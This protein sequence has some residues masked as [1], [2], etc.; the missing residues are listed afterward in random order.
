MAEPSNIIVE[1][2]IVGV[3][4]FKKEISGSVKEAE[5]I[6]ATLKDVSDNGSKAINT[7]TSSGK[8]LKTQMRESTAT[9][10][11]LYL[12]I[13]KLKDSGDKG[14]AALKD[15][16]ARA[17]KLSMEA[18]QLRDAMSDA[19][20]VI[21]GAGSDTRGLDR[22]LRTLTLFGGAAQIAEGASAA[23]G[24]ENENL[25]KTLVRLNA[26]MAITNGLQQIQD[27]LLKEDSVAKKAA[28]AATAVY[29]AV[30]GTST[31]AMK[32]FRI[33]L[34]ST[35]IGLFVVLL[36]SLIANW[37]KLTTSTN[38]SANA[39]KA[40]GDVFKTAF[41]QIMPA[42]EQ[43]FET[44]KFI[45]LAIKGFIDK[46]KELPLV[47]GLF[48]GLGSVIDNIGTII[49]NFPAYLAGFI[50]AWKQA[51]FGVVELVKGLAVNI[52][53]TFVAIGEGISNFDIKKP[54]ES[55]KKIGTAIGKEFGDAKDVFLDYGKSISDAF[56]NARNSV[57]KQGE[58]AQK[59]KKNTDEAADSIDRL[60]DST[61]KYN[62]EIEKAPVIGLSLLKQQLQEAEEALN[63]LV[64]I[65]VEQ[66][67]ENPF[68][69]IGDEEIIKSKENIEKLKKQIDEIEII[70][71]LD[72]PNKKNNID[73]IKNIDE[74]ILPEE[75]VK[76]NKERINRRLEKILDDIN[77][78]IKTNATD[79][80]IGNVL[81]QEIF[82]LNRNDFKSEMDYRIAV[83]SEA[84]TKIAGLSK[85][86]SS[87]TS[88][89]SQNIAEAETQRY[90]NLRSRGLISER[91]Y[92]RQL[93]R[94]KN[95][96]ARKQRRAELVQAAVNIPIAILGAFTQTQGGI[97]I[98]SI[99]ASVAGVFAAAQLAAIA[100]KPIPQFGGGGLFEG[101]GKV[102]GR[103][104]TQGGVNAS[105][106]GGEY[107]HN[108]KAVQ[109]YGLE[110]MEK[111]NKMK[112]P[113]SIVTI[114]DRGNNDYIQKAL[115]RSNYKL[116]KA[117]SDKNVSIKNVSEL[118][119]ALSPKKYV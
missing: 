6:E 7:L 27:E 77:N 21:S 19:S 25:Q 51:I 71:S 15:L 18:G 3:D 100:K 102:I 85:E 42:L 40:I 111:V 23:F 107:V 48:K 81:V 67:K 70:L 32:L 41:A 33:A 59:T 89:F 4:E 44:I 79:T 36:A 74:I 118:A 35:G 113:K 47:G 94:I 22:A 55:F 50:A 109:F 117:L 95:E 10:A 101:S 11:A 45:P 86:I 16:E 57:I 83:A 82:G 31:G 92:Q 58:L 61:K 24:V 110:F 96:Q 66:K 104:H 62:E 97:I 84:I 119:E 14:S 115:E 106:E 72:L 37:D 5:K 68:L 88:Q 114:K 54:L 9:L 43:I 69:L 39:F 73:S 99:A 60:T 26:I 93:A 30:V 17:A 108:N 105:L 76:K 112:Y 80:T 13:N 90:E 103:S 46:A 52:R 56:T 87:I 28:T 98:R 2:E 38:K 29:S 49:S 75:E 1:L 34:A 8:S 53:D 78:N 91:N 63:K 64:D 116:L 12:E 20:Q 65:K